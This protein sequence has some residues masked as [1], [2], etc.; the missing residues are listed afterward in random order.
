MGLSIN[1][2]VK[3]AIGFDEVSVKVRYQII[4]LSTFL[5]FPSSS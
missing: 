2:G 3:F 5:I 4:E 1:E